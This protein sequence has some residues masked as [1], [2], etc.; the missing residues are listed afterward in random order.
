ML[1]NDMWVI[2]GNR[3]S[4]ATGMKQDLARI[5]MAKELLGRKG[6]FLTV[7]AIDIAR[8]ELPHPIQKSLGKI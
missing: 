4:R 8:L 6:K 1:H 7:W 2:K 5:S 3:L